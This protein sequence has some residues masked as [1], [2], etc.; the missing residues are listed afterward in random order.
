MIFMFAIKLSSYPIQHKHLS[1]CLINGCTQHNRL[2]S[3]LERPMK[4]YVLSGG[5][6]HKFQSPLPSSIQKTDL[7]LIVCSH[8]DLTAFQAFHILF[9]SSKSSWQTILHISFFSSFLFF[10]TQWTLEGV[11]R[12]LLS[13][14]FLFTP[15]C[16]DSLQTLQ[17]TLC[18]KQDRT[19]S[20]TAFC[21]AGTGTDQRPKPRDNTQQ[22]QTGNRTS[23]ISK[24]CLK[25]QGRNYL[26]NHEAGPI[27]RRWPK[28]R[29]GATL[30]FRYN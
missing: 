11:L 21:P 9:F 24:Q 12:S 17:F 4:V 15:L 20:V 13:A 14:G 19:L 10:A 28:S 8:K 16:P 25:Y 6:N 1:V 23:S 22:P 30:C 2:S 29:Q 27:K 3:C 7:F 5:Q 26:E 18:G